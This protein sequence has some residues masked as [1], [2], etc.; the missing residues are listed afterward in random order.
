MRYR[1]S[2]AAFI[3]ITFSATV[4]A[5]ASLRA[6]VT[7]AWDPDPDPS[8]TGYRLYTGAH[9]G[10]YTQTVE[11]GNATS[12]LVSNLASGATYYFAVTAYNSASVES[13]PS[14]E[15]S[16]TTPSATPTP[17]PSATPTPSS[18]PTPTP[19]ATPTPAP[20]STP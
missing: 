16:Y 12:T 7:L 18:T 17:T 19:S 8:V 6:D 5:V 3:L 9:S 15:A 2:N 14:N 10:G 4:L 1:F 11:V 13:P 20:S